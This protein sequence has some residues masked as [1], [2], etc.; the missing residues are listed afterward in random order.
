MFLLS[1]KNYLHRC[2]IHHRR[3]FHILTNHNVFQILSLCQSIPFELICC[4]EFVT[5]F[6]SVI[7]FSHVWFFDKFMYA[8]IMYANN[9]HSLLNCSIFTKTCNTITAIS[10][11]FIVCNN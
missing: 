10:R 3:N 5:L 4:Q 11:F 2:R 7:M 8:N 9:S 1:I 6:F